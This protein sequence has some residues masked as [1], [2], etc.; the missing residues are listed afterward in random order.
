M[1]FKFS[2]LLTENNKPRKLVHIKWHFMGTC[3]LHHHCNLP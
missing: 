2:S 3:C 1:T